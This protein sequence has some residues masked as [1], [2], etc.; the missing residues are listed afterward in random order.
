MKSAA[1]LLAIVSCQYHG[2]IVITYCT[3]VT[4]KM[5]TCNTFSSAQKARYYNQ[6]VNTAASYRGEAYGTRRV[7]QEYMACA[8]SC[9]DNACYDVINCI[10]TKCRYLP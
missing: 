9:L 2:P 3:A 4:D 5:A 8:N 6:C 7:N 10:V 1:L